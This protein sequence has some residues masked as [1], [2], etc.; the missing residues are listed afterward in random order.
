MHL[1]LKYLFP[2]PEILADADFNG[3][4]LTKARIATIHQLSTAVLEDRVSFHAPIS[5]DRLRQALLDIKGIGEW[6]AQYILMRT[7][8][9]PNAMPCSDLGLLKA[10]SSDEK[11][12]ARKTT[13]GNGHTLETLAG[14]CSHAFVVNIGAIDGIRTPTFNKREIH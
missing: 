8:K 11:S 4:G 13:Q 3:I 2:G 5:P 7:I 6:T 9:I 12:G 10:V 14:L 1:S